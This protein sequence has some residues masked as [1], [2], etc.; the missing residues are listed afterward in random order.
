MAKAFITTFKYECEV[1]FNNSETNTAKEILSNCIKYILI[2]HDYKN[3]IMPI[4]YLKLTLTPSLYNAMVPQQGKSQIF[5]NLT[6]TRKQGSTSSCAKS[7]INDAFDYYMTDDPNAFKEMD[8]I[9]ESYGS[10]YKTCFIGLIKPSL[11]LLNQRSFEG[12]YKN[13]NMMSLVQNA[14]KQMD[15]VIQPFDNNTSIQTFACPPV[16]TV[17]QFLSY[18][19]SQYSF[20]NG[21]YIYYLDF[22]KVYLRSNDGS[23]IDAKDG[24]HKYVAFDIRDLTD[25]N[26]VSSGFVDDSSQDA[27][28]VY[29]NSEDAQIVVD[30]ITS[31]LSGTITSI[32][33]DNIT[34]MAVVD[35]SAITNISNS[36][37]G[38]II[39][40]SDP[41]AATN[42]AIQIAENSDTLVVTKADMDARVFTPNKVYMLSYYSDNPSYCGIYYMQKKQEIYMR[43]GTQINGQITMTLKKCAD[44]SSNS[45]S[46]SSLS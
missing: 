34:G 13:T 4:I 42:V 14:T 2:E 30:R 22:D 10:S 35:T 43:S 23:Y 33:D 32:S 20:Y 15:I 9:G 8:T 40:S 25:Y 38:T 39:T 19:N 36:N 28:I 44:F 6:R 3:R 45:K 26:A 27:Y 31:N 1:Y 24:D 29:V 11:T 41:N 18:L 21:N 17:G 12:I 16:T 37:S 5:L 7:V 46:G